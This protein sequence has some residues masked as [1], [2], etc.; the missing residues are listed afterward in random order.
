MILYSR[1]YTP[2]QRLNTAKE[3]MQALLDGQKV[4]RSN[5]FP[6]SYVHLVDGH[7][8]TREGEEGS[9]VVFE[10]DECFIYTRPK[11][12]VKSE[13]WFAIAHLWKDSVDL[14]WSGS[15]MTEA[16]AKHAY[17]NALAYYCATVEVEVER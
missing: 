9:L 13:R 6:L 5:W 11:R 4:R 16:E 2:G 15:F 1:T 12:K 8:V 14:A 10:A 7:L 17:P 3:V